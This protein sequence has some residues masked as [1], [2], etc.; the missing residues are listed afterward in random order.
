[1][2]GLEITGG[3]R[4]GFLQKE[5]DSANYGNNHHGAVLRCLLWF[6]NNDD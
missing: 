6:F 1:M 2:N 4:N 5:T 3:G